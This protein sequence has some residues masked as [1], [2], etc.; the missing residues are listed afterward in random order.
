MPI[1]LK[2][3]KAKSI[4]LPTLT[5]LCKER[6]LFAPEQHHLGLL[7]SIT[8]APQRNSPA[9]LGDYLCR[10]FPSSYYKQGATN[11]KAPMTSLPGLLLGSLAY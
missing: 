4:P 9:T 3:V 10:N 6:V 1:C 5:S 8:C 7:G 11:G 2:P